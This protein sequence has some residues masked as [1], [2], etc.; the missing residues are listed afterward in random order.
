VNTPQI[1]VTV[2]HSTFSHSGVIGNV[3]LALVVAVI[4]VAFMMDYTP[5][6]VGRWAVGRRVR[7]IGIYLLVVAAIILAGTFLV[8]KV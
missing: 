8:S 2:I 3:I 6:F 1:H 5:G 7:V 4:G